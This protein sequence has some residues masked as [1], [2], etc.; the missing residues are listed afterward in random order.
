M[1]L[2]N[3]IKKMVDFQ[4]IKIINYWPTMEEVFK[5]TI[6]DL[7]KRLLDAEVIFISVDGV[8]FPYI[9]IDVVKAEL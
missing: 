1:K 8:D 6:E 9:V 7:P 3:L 4:H 2:K 5:G